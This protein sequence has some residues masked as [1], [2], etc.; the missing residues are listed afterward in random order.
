MMKRKLDI[1]KLYQVHCEIATFLE[2]SSRGR[3]DSL[4]VVETRYGEHL[5]D[6]YKKTLLYGR[7]VSNPERISVLDDNGVLYVS[8]EDTGTSVP[9][10]MVRMTGIDLCSGCVYVILK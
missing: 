8:T 10:G 3:Y 2:T 4:A 7:E 1:N 5:L 6:L 9:Y